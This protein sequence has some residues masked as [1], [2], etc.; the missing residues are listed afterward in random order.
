MPLFNRGLLQLGSAATAWDS[1]ADYRVMLV[2]TAYTF[3]PDDNFVSDLGAVEISGAS[4]YAREATASRT[5][6]EDDAGNRVVY[7]LA[8]TDFGALGTG[9]TIGG[10]VIYRHVGAD[11]SANPLLGYINLTDTPTNGSTFSVD[12]NDTDGIWY[13]DSP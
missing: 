13:A 4:G 7:N 10:A 1:A 8:T 6:T 12:W 2:T 5:L 11:D 9:A 3:D